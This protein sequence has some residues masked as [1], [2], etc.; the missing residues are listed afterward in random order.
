MA[1]TPRSKSNEPDALVPTARL[2]VWQFQ[3]VRDVLVFGTFIGLIWAGYAMRAVT[4]PL[5]VALGLAY[6]FEPLVARLTRNPKTSRPLVV[7][8][9]L[10]SVGLL[11]ILALTFTIPLMVG[12]SAKFLD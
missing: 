10:I 1:Q 2:H 9:L 7:G 11:V 6:L 3:A 4:V 5:L 8:G 12:Q